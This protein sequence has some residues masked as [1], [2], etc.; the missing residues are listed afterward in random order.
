MG[1]LMSGKLT[2]YTLSRLVIT[3]ATVLFCSPNLHAHGLWEPK[4]GPQLEGEVTTSYRSKGSAVEG[5]WTIPGNLMGGEAHGTEQG[6]AIDSAQLNFSYFDEENVY[7]IAELGYHSS[8]GHDELELEQAFLGALVR[9]DD[10][11]WQFEAGKMSAQFSPAYHAHATD[12]I[13]LDQALAYDLLYGGHASEI[14]ARM[15]LSHPLGRGIG[16]GIFNGEQ[17]PA[18]RQTDADHAEPGRADLFAYY[19]FVFDKAL[20]QTRVWHQWFKARDRSDE[21]LENHSDDHQHTTQNDENDLRFDGE[22]RISGVRAKLIWLDWSWAKLLLT[23]E[24]ME[25]NISAT[26]RDSLRTA[27]LESTVQAGWAQVAI[28]KGDHSLA[29]AYDRTKTDNT[30]IGDAGPTIA[31][32]A[33][34]MGM[35]HKPERL[36]MVYRHQWREQLSW[37]I[38]GHADHSAP[39][40]FNA[41]ILALRWQGKF[42]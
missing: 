40:S 20:L 33:G 35:N 13:F 2:H 9:T 1:A 10:L 19:H 15:L 23:T 37:S 5:L 31:N 41:M 16:L 38:E 22:T 39:K 32:T 27:M 8:Q 3:F 6:F 30:L 28:E 4:T 29:L 17:F 21:R 25:A 7:G 12:R 42:W 34:L 14:G 18:A 26:L 36:R 11:Q 24:L